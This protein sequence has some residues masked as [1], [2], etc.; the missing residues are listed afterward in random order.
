ML[1]LENHGPGLPSATVEG[2]AKCLLVNWKDAESV[3]RVEKKLRAALESDPP[4]SLA[5][6]AKEFR[7]NKATLRRVFPDLAAQ[8]AKRAS[9]YYR[10]SI[11]TGK[12]AKELR[13]ALKES[14]PPPL[15]AVSK[16]LGPGASSTVLHKKFPKESRRIVERYRAHAKRRLNDISIEKRLR[17]ALKREPPP[18]MLGVSRELGVAAP[19]LHRKFPTLCGS[20]SGRFAGYRRY[21]DAN[22]REHARA[23]IRSICERAVLEG[24][25]PSD[26]MVRSQLTVPCQSQAISDIRREVIAAITLH[27]GLKK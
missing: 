19:T 3:S 5:K 25:Y 20:I 13:A 23:E 17:A 1:T 6:L 18:S 10:P 16:R 4:A 2:S 27:K 26:A 9:D 24:V 15:N 14:P 21:R 7:C 8:V 11:S 12:M 22:N